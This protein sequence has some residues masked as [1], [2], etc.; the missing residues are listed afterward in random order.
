MKDGTRVRKTIAYHEAIAFETATKSLPPYL[1]VPPI[2][3]LTKRRGP[4]GINR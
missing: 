3:Q 1:G 4:A 2:V